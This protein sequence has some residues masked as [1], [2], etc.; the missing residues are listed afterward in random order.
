MITWTKAFLRIAEV[1]FDEIPRITEID[2]IR[3]NQRN[4]P[5]ANLRFRDFFSIVVDLTLPE[6]VLFGALNRDTRYEV[7]LAT[8][9]DSVTYV[10]WDSAD[11]DTTL[12]FCTFYDKFAASKGLPPSNRSRLLAASNGGSL[13]LSSIVDPEG[14]NIVW[15]AYYRLP[16]RVRLLHSASLYRSAGTPAEKQQTGRANRFHHWKDIASFRSL[17]ISAYDF[18]GW[19][20]GNSDPERL[21]INAFKEEFGGTIVKQYSWED[22]ITQRGKLALWLRGLYRNI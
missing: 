4:V 3:Y 14:K 17:G 13:S 18:G 1:Y 19:Y 11:A 6:E 16:D 10:N 21:R 5:P 2:I 15:H 8:N 12:T 20:E 9:R 7:R 22:G